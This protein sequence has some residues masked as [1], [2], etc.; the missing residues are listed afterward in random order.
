[1]ELIIESKNLQDYLVEYPPYIVYKTEGIQKLIQQFKDTSNSKIEQAKSAF[2]WSRDSI[3][4]SFDTKNPVVSI[5]AEDTLNN[6]EGICFAKAHIL[7]SIL[8]G[9]GIPTGFCYQ[10]VLRKG[11]IESGYALHGLNAIY[12]DDYGWKRI[13]PRGNKPGINSQFNLE[14]EQLAYPIRTELGEIDY[15]NV[16]ISPLDSVIT[17]MENSATTQELFF[18]R[19]EKI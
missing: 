11:T 3:K 16:F 18:K 8:R 6:G 12:L 15:P 9:L 4:H 17:A 5:G 19:P 13:D 7:A 2:E 10:R 1:M 14:E